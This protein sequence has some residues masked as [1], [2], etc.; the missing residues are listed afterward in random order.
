[1]LRPV[2]FALFGI[3]SLSALASPASAPLAT[4]AHVD[5]TRYAGKWFEVARIPN[6]F[7]RKCVRDVT[8]EYTLEKN[9][10]RVRNS[11]IQADGKLRSANGKA[12]VVDTHS[13]AKLKVTFFWPFYGK[14]WIIGLDPN[15]RWAVVGEPTRKYLWVLARTSVLSDDERAE[16][17]RVIKERGYEHASLI[18]NPSR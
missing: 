15:Y 3:S 10:I 8:A 9:A 4:V 2:I 13:N 17:D 1:M 11:C 12:L 5:I 18:W 14:Y 7:E 6:R 16:V